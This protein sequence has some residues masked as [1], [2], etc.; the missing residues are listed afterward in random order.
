VEA[1][2]QARTIGGKT[3]GSALHDSKDQPK[4]QRSS[5]IR[6]SLAD[7]I[8]RISGLPLDGDDLECF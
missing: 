2:I 3:C 7:D 4:F 1:A 8:R 5:A 6:Q